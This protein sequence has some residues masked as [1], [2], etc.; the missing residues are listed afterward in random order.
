[1]QV[2]NKI[3]EK[4]YM[5]FFKREKNK[6]IYLAFILIIIVCGQ[7]FLPTPFRRLI[8]I[9]AS[10]WCLLM[11]H[12]LHKIIREPDLQKK[13]R[14]NKG[15]FCYMIL[16]IACV[17]LLYRTYI[18]YGVIVYSM[19]MY[20]SIISVIF[21]L[22]FFVYGYVVKQWKLDK[23]FFAIAIPI[24]LI[25][26]VIV[27]ITATP[28]EPVHIMK[29]IALSNE[30]MGRGTDSELFVIKSGE[31]VLFTKTITGSDSWIEVNNFYEKMD[32]NSG[33]WNE[34][35]KP[36]N[37]FKGNTV[38]Y[39]ISA[40]V[41]S[42]GRLMDGNVLYYMLFARFANYLWYCFTV[43]LA[44]HFMPTRKELTAVIALMPMSVQQGVSFSYD[45]FII[46]SA[47]FL[48]SAALYF[49]SNERYDVKEHKKYC[50][51]VLFYSIS[52]FSLKHHVYSLIS[53]FP[54][55]IISLDRL[56]M[57]DQVK[58]IS[59]RVLMCLIAV[60]SLYLIFTVYCDLNGISG[61]FPEPLN[62]LEWD[63]S[64]YVY[65]IGY[66]LNH[67]VKIIMLMLNSLYINTVFYVESAFNGPLRWLDFNVPNHI[68]S[69]S[70]LLLGFMTFKRTNESLILNKNIKIIGSTIIILTIGMIFG[71]MLTSWTGL[72][73]VT[74]QGVQGRYILPMMNMIILI[75]FYS[76]TIQIKSNKD[77]LIFGVFE[78]L[79]M[80]CMIKSIILAM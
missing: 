71:G 78:C 70:Y 62:E 28:D 46:S 30:M 13:K 36:H 31:E 44:I 40:L 21:C 66:V 69:L 39:L 22:L 5:N 10:I 11:C 65:S 15:L 19:L 37:G 56:K 29:S 72:D 76:E 16:L 48:I 4:N 59:K 45:S 32:T 17:Y 34:V 14:Y 26:N 20:I 9:T 53:L 50:A 25:M 57:T 75:P 8:G 80:L 42:I 2:G 54:W 68:M 7:S 58:K 73:S 12:V 18:K 67:P 52:L 79:I 63:S 74:V 38:A 51:L 47:I 41:I 60:I 24:G 77:K 49:Y 61:L 6:L 64:Q 35:I 3:G 55:L 27:P 33:V 1:M 43:C 23:L